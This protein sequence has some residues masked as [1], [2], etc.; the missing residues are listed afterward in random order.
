VHGGAEH[1]LFHHAQ[2]SVAHVAIEVYVMQ[3]G[4]MHVPFGFVVI[5]LS[6]VHQQLGDGHASRVVKDSHMRAWHVPFASRRQRSIGQAIA[7][8]PLKTK[9]GG[10]M[11]TLD[12]LFQLQR[13]C[14]HMPWGYTEHAGRMHVAVFE[15]NMQR[16]LVQKLA[17]LRYEHGMST[18]DSAVAVP[19]TPAAQWQLAAAH[20]VELAIMAHGIV[21]HV[22]PRYRQRCFGHVAA[23]VKKAH[24]GVMHFIIVGSNRQPCVMGHDAAVS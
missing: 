24:G 16:S 13:G 10:V 8:S 18:Q 14:G 17:G 6:V 22:V 3:G 12:S 4:A 15:S 1:W 2:R 9:H 11:H 23:S 20:S 19:A 7:S 5:V 21:A